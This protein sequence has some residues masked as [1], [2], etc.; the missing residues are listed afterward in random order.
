MGDKILWVI[1]Q[2]AL[3]GAL[4][5]IAAYFGAKSKARKKSD[6]E[7]RKKVEALCAGTRNILRYDIIQIHDKYEKLGYCP[8]SIKEALEDSY[9]SYHALGGN[10]IITKLYNDV[11]ALPEAPTDSR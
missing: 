9:N 8:I 3:T 4:G 11:M 6:E 5:A 1:I 7:A 10:G 2:W